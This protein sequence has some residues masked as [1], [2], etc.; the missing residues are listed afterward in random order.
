MLDSA[1]SLAHTDDPQ[2]HGHFSTSKAT[3]L[4]AFIRHV[5]MHRNWECV[6]GKLSS[7][8]QSTRDGIYLAWIVESPGEHSIRSNHRL[9]LRSEHSYI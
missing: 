5:I 6:D 1:H 4:A 7:P 2:I 3:R 8:S 9:S